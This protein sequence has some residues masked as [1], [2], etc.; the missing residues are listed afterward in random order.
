MES[1][2]SSVALSEAETDNDNEYPVV[3]V[4][5]M[6]CTLTVVHE[7]YNQLLLKYSR[8]LN[9]ID[10]L[11]CRLACCISSGDI[12]KIQMKYQALI[13][14]M[15]EFC[16]DD[17]TKRANYQ[18]SNKNKAQ[19]S[20]SSSHTSGPIVL[21]D[22]EDSLST[23]EADL[24]SIPPE[25][26]PEPTSEWLTKSAEGKL[27][28]NLFSVSD[29]HN[30]LHLSLTDSIAEPV[31][32]VG[33][34]DTG[35]GH[36]NCA[37]ECEEIDACKLGVHQAEYINSTPLTHLSQRRRHT[38]VQ[39]NHHQIAVV[40]PAQRNVELC[41]MGCCVAHSCCCC[42]HAE[43]S[44]D[45]TH[46]KAAQN[47]HH[48]KSNG[49]G[50]GKPATSRTCNYVQASGDSSV[51]FQKIASALDVAVQFAGELRKNSRDL[52]QQFH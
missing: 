2:S 30:G 49:I 43:N 29:N 26:L 11:K 1:S 47:S 14:E 10:Q 16:F 3:D 45:E 5:A 52:L 22:H 18:P 44:K 21:E 50:M 15:E 9:I 51:S 4:E 37:V 38:L 12:S 23:A 24:Y 8:A 20:S 36:T 7:Q 34:E 35:G 32:L 13:L 48:W 19:P 17:I 27:F 40:Y 39:P 25:T 42:Q 46:S 6:N 33:Q 31:T 41:S 28:G